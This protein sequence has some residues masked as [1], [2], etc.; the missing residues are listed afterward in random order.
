[1]KTVSQ[2]SSSFYGDK[3]VRKADEYLTLE[4]PGSL[5]ES[6]FLVSHSHQ[7]CKRATVTAR[8][9]QAEVLPVLL[10]AAPFQGLDST[11]W[12]FSLASPWWP[13]TAQP[14]M[15]TAPAL[16]QSKQLLPGVWTCHVLADPWPMTTILLLQPGILSPP[17]AIGSSNSL[18][19]FSMNTTCFRKLSKTPL[20]P[21]KEDL[22]EILRSLRCL[23]FPALRAG[24]R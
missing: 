7:Q 21:K 20:F 19:S 8:S 4:I 13:R 11:R 9:F 3:K 23:P 10:P 15:H 1:M 22:I 5:S 24:T 14:G 16:L 6:R 2:Q 17:S 18:S 12:Q